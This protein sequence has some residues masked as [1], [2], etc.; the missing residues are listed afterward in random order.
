[1]SASPA[2]RTDSPTV[3]GLLL[4]AGEGRRFGGPKALA[5]TD[6]TSWVERSVHVLDTGGCDL[7]LVVVGASAPEVQRKVPADH[8]VVEAL[9]WAEGMSASLRVGLSTLADAAV[10]RPE[11]DAALVHLVDL[12]GVGSEVVERMVA[13]ADAGGARDV[14]ARAAYGGEPGHP[15]LIGRSHW[16]GIVR[17]ARGDRGARDY[18]RERE[19]R[20]VECG[21]R[22]S[23]TDVDT[24]PDS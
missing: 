23:G 20:L 14:L 24:R 16:A 3:A 10:G 6:G 4:A 11:V 15:V 2:L 17:T 12:P 9:D 22:G 19:V 8:G 1:M 18:L 5:E 13:L 7:V 21:D